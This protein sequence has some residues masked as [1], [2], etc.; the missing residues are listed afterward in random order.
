MNYYL[1]SFVLNFNLN[2]VEE[3]NESSHFAQNTKGVNIKED[4]ISNYL[5][6]LQDSR[7]SSK[8]NGERTK[9]KAQQLVTPPHRKSSQSDEYDFVYPRKVNSTQRGK[10]SGF[11]FILYLIHYFN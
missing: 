11:I 3:N 5:S 6:L 9:R 2:L 8:N 4:S 10:L 7:I 1:Q